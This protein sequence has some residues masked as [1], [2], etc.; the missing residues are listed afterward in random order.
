MRKTEAAT[1]NSENATGSSR[2][3]PSKAE[4][5]A[6]CSA[7]V[8]VFVLVV[9][10][11][12]L[13]IALFAVNRNLR[14]KSLFLVINMA[15]ADLMLG[16]LSLPL[17]IY[18]VGYSFELWRGAWSMS[19]SIFFAIVDTFFSQA[20]LISAAFISGERFYAIYWP[21]KH[22][23]LSMRAYHIII[24]T[25]WVLTL[26][27]TALFSTTRFLFSVKRSMY[28]WMPYVSIITFTIC[29]C[30]IGIWRKFRRGNIASQQE[31]RNSLNKRLTKTL[32][33]VSILALLCWIPLVVL[34]GLIIVYDVQIPWKFY[35]LVGL[36]YFSNSFANPVMYALRI[37]EFREALVLCC[38]KR[39]AA[40]N[41]VNI[42]RRSKKTS[43]T[44]LRT[45]RTDNSLLQLSFKQEVLDT[46]L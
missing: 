14:K 7:F 8:L 11:N 42:N 20:S 43:A 1:N 18:Y 10:G 13:T 16:I 22:R 44:E 33:I 19:L 21:F 38:L 39:R 15:F 35:C 30:N 29:G 9:V 36:I 40:P 45:L 28:Y 2:N 26:L 6:L 4:G 32:L 24:F 3:V 46:K 5:I 12:L 31:T 34:N 41:M 23:T 17:S 37:P 27:I 25:L